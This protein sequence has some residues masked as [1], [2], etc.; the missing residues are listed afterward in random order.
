MAALSQR[1]KSGQSAQCKLCKAKLKTV[2]RSTKRSHEHL[3][4]VYDINILKREI[5]DDDKS[6]VAITSKHIATVGSMLS[7]VVPK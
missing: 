3:K 2:G 7:Y 6:S 5:A 4:R 1:K